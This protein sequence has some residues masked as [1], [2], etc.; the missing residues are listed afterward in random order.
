[1]RA[2]S[3]NFPRASERSDLVLIAD[4]VDPG[5]RVLDVGC[6]DGTLLEM[7][8]NIKD[9]DAR[10]VE[11]S[12]TGVNACVA[13][14]LSVVQGDAD[15]DLP[16]YPDRAFDYVILSQTIQATHKP[17]FV[18]DELLR[19][20]QRVIVS[21]PNFGHWKVRFHLLMSGR[22]PMTG[23][24]DQPWYETPNIHLC[25]IR[26]FVALCENM[27]VKIEYAYARRG[28]RIKMRFAKPGMLANLI[29]DEAIFILSRSD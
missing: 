11:L 4:L 15:A 8:T 14:G 26:D 23:L 25:T 10:G 28:N 6:G 21:F 20:G 5:S 24:L 3:E 7:L 22:M 1:M 17:K 9:V 12:Q 2:P 19:I 16:A 27:N 29:A 18:L 13:R